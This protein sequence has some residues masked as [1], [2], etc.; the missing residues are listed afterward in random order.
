MTRCNNNAKYAS[1]N[2]SNEM[3]ISSIYFN[4]NIEQIV[5]VKKIF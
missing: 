2:N 4:E 1:K 5:T 3:A